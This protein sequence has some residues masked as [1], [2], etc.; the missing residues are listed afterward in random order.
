MGIHNPRFLSN[1]NNCCA[2]STGRN[3]DV[4]TL[5]LRN[6]NQN[7]QQY[8]E[9][10]MNKILALVTTKGGC[11]K[12]TLAACLAGEFQHWNKDAALL[13]IDPQR[14]LSAWHANEGALNASLTVVT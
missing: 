7:K 9:Q 1:C 5:N 12:S 8:N 13:D 6:A 11:G 4:A 10:Q 3:N 14:T 2:T